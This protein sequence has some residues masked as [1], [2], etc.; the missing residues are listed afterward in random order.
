MNEVHAQGLWDNAAVTVVGSDHDGN[1][2]QQLT[3]F[4]LMVYALGLKTSLFYAGNI[5]RSNAA[6]FLREWADGLENNAAKREMIEHRALFIAR[7]ALRTAA[8]AIC[9]CGY[10]LPSNNDQWMP[11]LHKPDC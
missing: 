7:A 5:E 10:F 2:S 4:G 9:N 3:P 11:N 6:R 8:D 1:E